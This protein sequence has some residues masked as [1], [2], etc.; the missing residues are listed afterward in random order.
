MATY[1]VING[2]ESRLSLVQS[3]NTLFGISWYIGIQ[4]NIIVRTTIGYVVKL[5]PFSVG[6]FVSWLLIVQHCLKGLGL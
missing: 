3:T 5:R 4:R 6:S 1:A 2:L